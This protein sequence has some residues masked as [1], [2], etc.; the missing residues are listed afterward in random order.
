L[1]DSGVQVD[2]GLDVSSL[3]TFSIA[4]IFCWRNQRPLV[5]SA[6]AI[7]SPQDKQQKTFRLQVVE[8]SDSEELIQYSH[9]ATIPA[10]VVLFSPTFVDYFRSAFHESL[11]AITFL[12]FL[13]V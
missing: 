13:T 4:R 11:K 10:I 5:R 9:F 2:T 6:E 12:T 3:L 7:T 1:A 8:D